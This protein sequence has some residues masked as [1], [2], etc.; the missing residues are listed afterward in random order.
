MSDLTV[1]GKGSPI[2]LQKFLE[3]KEQTLT[4]YNLLID[5]SGFGIEKDSKECIYITPESRKEQSDYYNNIFDGKKVPAYLY[6]YL[7]FM[8]VSENRTF[9]Y[10]T[11]KDVVNEMISGR[12][13]EQSIEY[14]TIINL[15]KYS[16]SNLESEQVIG[17]IM[18]LA[19][20]LS[21]SKKQGKGIKVYISHPEYGLHPSRQSMFVDLLMKIQNEYGLQ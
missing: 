11:D 16:K 5:G 13:N 3:L 2:S 1:N 17:M 8:F 15:I 18:S 14:K 7:H 6:R 9:K 21:A 19:G 20:I 10:N 4:K 12:I